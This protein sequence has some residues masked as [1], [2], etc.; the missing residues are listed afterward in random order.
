MDFLEHDGAGMER[1]AANAIGKPGI[2]D[3]MLF[4]ESETAAYGGEFAKSRE[5]S[6]R[7]A[8]SAQRIDEEETAADR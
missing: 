2:D 1:E 8:D 4:L 5:L 6:R 7:A 3:Q